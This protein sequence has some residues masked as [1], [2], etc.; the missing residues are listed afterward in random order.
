MTSTGRRE[1]GPDC[2]R[3]PVNREDITSLVIH[4]FANPN[5]TQKNKVRE[6][7]ALGLRDN[8]MAKGRA[9]VRD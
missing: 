4:L 8:L 6:L 7:K 3:L 5:K 2:G 9:G 1:T